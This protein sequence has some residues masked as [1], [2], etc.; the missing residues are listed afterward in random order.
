ML[1]S[2]DVQFTTGHVQLQQTGPETYSGTVEVPEGAM[3][4]YAYDRWNEE[5]CC[6][7]ARVTRE[8][9]FT[10][11]A[12]GYRLLLV[13]PDIEHVDDTVPQWN[14]IG[15]EFTQ[16]EVEGRVIDDDTGMPLMDVDITVAGVHVASRYDGTFTVPGVIPGTHRLVAYTVKG[17]FGAVQHQLEVGEDGISGLEIRMKKAETTAV[18]FSV[19]LPAETPPEVGV[20]LAGNLWQLGARPSFPA[21]EPAVPSGISMPEMVRAGDVARLTVELPVGAYVEYFYTLGSDVSTEGASHNRRFRSFVVEP[22]QPVRNDAVDYWGNDGWP[23]VTL[24]VTVPAN[25]PEG[26]PVYLRDGPTYRMHQ[27]GPFEYITA[28]GSHPPGAE[29]RFRISLG[30]DHNGAD[31]SPE[32]EDS[33]D[34]AIVFPES[35]TTINVNVSKWANLPDPTLRAA[36]GS[37]T[38]KFRLSV[39]LETPDDATIVLMGDRPAVGS[40]GTVMTQVPGNPWMYEADVN[41]GHDGLLRYRYA[42]E[43]TGLSS[44]ELTVNTDYHGQQ[45]NDFVVSWG[46]P[47]AARDGW[48]SGIYMPDFWSEGFLP[49]SDSAFSA[50]IEANGEW[51]AIS[52][53]WSFGQI[54]PLPYLES[55]P[56]RTWTVL[57]PI[58]DIRAQAAIAR[59]NGLKVF[60][61][62]QMNPEIHPDWQQQTVDAGSREWWGQWLEQA[63]AQ[64]MW[65]AVVAEEIEAELLMLPGY[66]FHVFPPPAFFADP[67]YAPEFDLKVQAMIAKVRGVY[68]GKILIS[69]SQTEYDFPSLAD[70]IGVTTYDLGVPELPAAATFEQLEAH[71]SDR[72]EQDLD[73]RWERW[74]KPVMFYTIHAPARAQAGDEFGQLFQAAAHEAMFQQ[75]EARPYVVG[76]FTW[77]FDMV[78]ATDFETDGVRDRAGEAVLAKWYARLSGN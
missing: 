76:A 30:D 23:L 10:G 12:I 53:V 34:R 51:V 59:A 58:E 44:K 6:A 46:D 4:R 54:Q 11:D 69:G 1:H 39:P 63:E 26:V 45:V 7:A 17:D 74:G 18:E 13:G 77:A 5:G 56:V 61:A 24:R 43:G 52:S 48:V 75:I 67:D 47:P 2:V 33:G 71:Y 14:D 3:L 70:Y 72:F 28:V 27:I 37:L 15:S 9:L 49:T 41:F 22:D 50:A 32:L 25:T 19:H 21:N 62:P 8:S 16:A 73:N 42:I 20:F 68:S 65:N 55:R 78:G 64:W 66:V 57:T 36:G 40:E 31:G 35:D 38:V 60:L 29:Y